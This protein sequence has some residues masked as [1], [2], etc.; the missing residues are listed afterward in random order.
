MLRTP[1][2]MPLRKSWTCL[3]TLLGRHVSKDHNWRY[4]GSASRC[5]RL[6]WTNHYPVVQYIWLCH[7]YVS[8]CLLHQTPPVLWRFSYSSRWTVLCLVS[9]AYIVASCSLMEHGDFKMAAPGTSKKPGKRAN[10]GPI[11]LAG[12]STDIRYT[13]LRKSSFD[14]CLRRSSQWKTIATKNGREMH[15]CLAPWNAIYLCIYVFI[16]LFFLLF[17]CLF[18]YLFILFFRFK[19]S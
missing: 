10:N 7:W 19:W 11:Q 4:Q 14:N 17:V 16:Y 5:Q 2:S 6:Y 15:V 3:L 8:H 12:Y 9:Q 18:I 13:H 1:V